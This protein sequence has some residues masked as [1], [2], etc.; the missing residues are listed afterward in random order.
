VGNYNSIFTFR[1]MLPLLSLEQET[2]FGAKDD[3]IQNNKAFRALGGC[4]EQGEHGVEANR[5]LEISKDCDFGL[6]IALVKGDTN[7]SMNE[8]NAIPVV[9]Q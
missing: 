4:K 6:D 7:R 8:F 9:E 5:L 1:K 3:Y 2:E